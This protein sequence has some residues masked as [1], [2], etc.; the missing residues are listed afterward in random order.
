[1]K[2]THNTKNRYTYILIAVFSLIFTH[3]SLQSRELSPKYNQL[4]KA[5]NSYASANDPIVYYAVHNRGNLQLSIY[6]CLL[7]G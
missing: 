5:H 3:S 1:M 4:S 2:N 7:C 6:P